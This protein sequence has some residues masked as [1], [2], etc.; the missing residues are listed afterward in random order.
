[1]V[2]TSL[3]TVACTQSH[4]LGKTWDLPK[5]D[6]YFMINCNETRSHEEDKGK[7]G[8]LRQRQSLAAHHVKLPSAA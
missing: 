3:L 5:I 6:N 8:S 7:G 1:M 4:Y 2:L